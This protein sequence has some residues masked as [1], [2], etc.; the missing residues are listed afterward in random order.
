MKI[1]VMI[2]RIH[3]TIMYRIY[4][5]N[6]AKWPYRYH[7]KRNCDSIT[8]LCCQ[9]YNLSAQELRFSWSGGWDLC[10]RGDGGSDN[11]MAWSWP[12]SL[13]GRP[14]TFRPQNARLSTSSKAHHRSIHHSPA[15]HT[16]PRE[17]SFTLIFPA[18][19]INLPVLSYLRQFYTVSSASGDV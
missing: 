4:N 12:S 7:L 3:N 8:I 19:L 1:Y 13:V 14:G 16:A 9:N 5:Y 10:C 15:P 6:H 11:A 18:S 17:H 2:P